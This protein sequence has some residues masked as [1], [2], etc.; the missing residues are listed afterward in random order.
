MNL[1]LFTQRCLLLDVNV[2]C[3]SHLPSLLLLLLVQLAVPLLF[4]VVTLLLLLHFENITQ[5]WTVTKVN[6]DN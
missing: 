5:H 2:H 1:T 6:F 3:R 4:A